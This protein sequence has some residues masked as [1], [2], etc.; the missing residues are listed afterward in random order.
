MMDVNKVELVMAGLSA[1]KTRVNALVSRPSTP[2][3]RAETWMPP[4]KAGHD[5]ANRI[6]LIET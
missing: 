4:P 5:E 1:S 2:W 6:N 3:R